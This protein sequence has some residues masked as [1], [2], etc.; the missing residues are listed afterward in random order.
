MLHILDLTIFCDLF[1]S[2]YIVWTDDRAIFD[3]PSRDGR[4][5]KI[6]GIYSAWCTSNSSFTCLECFGLFGL[7][8]LS[9][10][11]EI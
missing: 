5:Q 10:H 2:A 4:L 1:A 6:H 9:E 3:A 7:S 8:V 11:V